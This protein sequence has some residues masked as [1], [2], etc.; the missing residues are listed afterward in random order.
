MIYFGFLVPR[1]QWHFKFVA[2]T[3]SLFPSVNIP[4]ENPGFSAFDAQ[5]FEFRRNAARRNRQMCQP[6][7]SGQ[8]SHPASCNAT[9]EAS[10]RAW[11]SAR[12]AHT[13]SSLAL[14][15]RPIRLRLL[16]PAGGRHHI[17]SIHRPHCSGANGQ[18]TTSRIAQLSRSHLSPQHLLTARVGSAAMGN[19]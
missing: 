8:V 3:E 1:K 5:S 10:T 17:P 12:L 4:V 11:R 13:G 15:P 19:R 2:E 18:P 7:F 6:T 9:A 14:L 16:L